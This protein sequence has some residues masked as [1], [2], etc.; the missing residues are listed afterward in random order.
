MSEDF[1]KKAITISALSMSKIEVAF[2]L[3]NIALNHAESELQQSLLVPVLRK[4]MESIEGVRAE[5]AEQTQPK[6]PSLIL[7]KWNQPRGQVALYF[8]CQMG[9][10][11]LHELETLAE[12]HCD[13]EHLT[14]GEWEEGESSEIVRTMQANDKLENFVFI[15][16]TGIYKGLPSVTG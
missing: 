13:R 3:L 8:D 15:I 12:T 7:T 1:T 9:E 6:E 11:S 4:A 14:C 5:I 10:G 16:S 2:Q